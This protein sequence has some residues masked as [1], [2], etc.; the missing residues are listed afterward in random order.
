[1][2]MFDITQDILDEVN[3]YVNT[4]LIDCM[5][6]KKM[7]HSAITFIL[8]TLTDAIDEAQDRLDNDEN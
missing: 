6:D 8:E 2:I 7:N 3:I 4:Y 1:M 5:I